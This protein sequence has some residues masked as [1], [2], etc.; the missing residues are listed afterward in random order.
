MKDLISIADLTT[1]QVKDLLRLAHDIK[2]N[3]DNYRQALAHKTL[4]MIFQK[5]STRTRVSFEV[6]MAQLGGNAL[7]LS[8]RDIQL[9]RGEP[10]S[11]TA[12]VLSRYVDGIM[13]RTYAHS[14]VT[15]LARFATIPVINGLTDFNH[16]CQGLAD[17][18][19]IDEHFSRVH[20]LPLNEL[21]LC[22]IGDGNN[23]AH[24]LAFAAAQVG[25]DFYCATPVGY[26]MDANVYAEA[27][28]LGER[29]GSRVRQTHNPKE[30]AKG[31]HIVYTDVWASMG[32]EEEQAKR[33]RDFSGFQVDDSIMQLTDNKS[34]F[35][36]CL[37]AHRGEEVSASVCDGPRSKIFDQAENRLHMQKAI[38]Y[39][40]MK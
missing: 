24:S 22:Y 31:A 39:T 13:A 3:P 4:A 23:M 12:Q 17:L 37:P 2:T 36:H 5:S 15:T 27:Q 9:G 38:M 14:D 8:S 30:A 34:I 19:T 25:M 20:N 6:G 28:I 11:D 40:L 26:E 18:Q 7:F 21:R 33:E 10:L 16:P 29:T 1:E 35:L 32:Q